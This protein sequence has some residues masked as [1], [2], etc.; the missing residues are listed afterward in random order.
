MSVLL[1][2]KRHIDYMVNAAL[3]YSRGSGFVVYHGSNTSILTLDLLD[4]FGQRLA[5]ANAESFE[6]RYSHNP[7]AMSELAR[8]AIKDY[9]FQPPN[10]MIH[11]PVVLKQVRFY[12]YQTC[13]HPTWTDSWA[14]AF[15]ESL[16]SAAI[17]NIDGYEF[18]PWGIEEGEVY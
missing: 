2:S 7:E 18:A 16:T 11:A 10:I 17:Q 12:E 9:R 8:G 6:N 3:T 14:Y 4:D 13:E 5:D 1:V 15:C